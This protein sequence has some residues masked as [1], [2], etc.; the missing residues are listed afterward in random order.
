MI[1]LAILLQ[2]A[3]FI[4]YLLRTG[5]LVNAPKVPKVYHLDALFSNVWRY[6]R[7]QY[8]G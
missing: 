1:S 2:L 8:E 7:W 4:I 5:F 6:F 3:Y